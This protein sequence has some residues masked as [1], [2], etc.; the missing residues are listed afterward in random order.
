MNR[1]IALLP[2]ILVACGS[3][4][5]KDGGEPL[6]PDAIVHPGDVP[7]GD[8]LQTSRKAGF[9]AMCEELAKADVVYLGEFHT[10]KA[11]HDM[12]L[13][14]I[15][16]LHARGRL[17]AIGMER[18]Q[19]PYQKHLD[20]FVAHR[21]DEAAMLERTEWKKRWGYDYALYKPILDFAREHR[22]EVVALNVSTET[23]K[24]VAEKGRDGLTAAQRADLPEEDRSFP[25]YR[26]RIVSV[27][28]MHLPH[29][30]EPDEETIERYHRGQLLWDDV[31]ADSVVRW[32]RRAP[33]GTQM[34]AVIGGGHVSGGWGVP[35]R[36]RKRQGGVHRTVVMTIEPAVKDE[37][38]AQGYADFVWAAK[39][40]RLPPVPM[41]KETAWN[42]PEGLGHLESTPPELRDSIDARVAELLADDAASALRAQMKLV[43]IGKPAFP[44]VLQ[45]LA[46][47]E[48]AFH[49]RASAARRADE[50][51]RW[52]GGAD[53]P[54]LIGARTSRA[55]FRE[56]VEAHAARWNGSLSSLDALPGPFAAN[57]ESAAEN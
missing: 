36:A 39:G 42:A 5:E 23:R 37:N 8:I 2:F 28:K 10:L 7:D 20:D 55:T 43:A 46:E 27:A 26:D 57:R 51:L 22:I 16:Q 56:V 50:C 29:G 52:M 12:Q 49:P 3:T 11:H 13:E 54:P 47:M 6:S 21:I 34:A 38:M 9:E 17:D 14:I 24:T 35:A 53:E 44:V 45:A 15:R 32:M 40:V 1:A 18:F 25:G 33:K 4:K 48:P 19:R 30:Q 31:M 41:P